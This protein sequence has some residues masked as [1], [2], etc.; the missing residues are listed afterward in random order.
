M[1]PPLGT[2]NITATGKPPGTLILSTS[3]SGELTGTAFGFPLTAVFDETSQILSF[4]F[5]TAGA[6]APFAFE[7]YTGTL[8]QAYDT[9]NGLVAGE[10]VPMMLAG[11][12]GA[13]TVGGAIGPFY[14]L[15]WFATNQ[16]KFK[17]KE[18]KEHKDVKDFKDGK[19]HKD[20]LPDKVHPDKVPGDKLPE[21]HQRESGTDAA[22]AT[23]MAGDASSEMRAATGKSFVSVEER[24]SVG[25]AALKGD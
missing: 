8:F 5:A 12:F 21:F 24:P 16:Q 9:N 17:E 23:A 19:E 4:S 25:S 13:A 7:V 10:G 1:A 18:G 2:W 15:G 20:A 11:N 14:Q 6:P 3:A 22:S